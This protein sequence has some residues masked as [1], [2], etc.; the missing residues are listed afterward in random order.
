MAE[1]ELCLPYRVLIGND[2]VAPFE[3]R[4]W[5]LPNIDQ[6]LMYSFIVRPRGQKYPGAFR[7]YS[8][9]ILSVTERQ[10]LPPSGS[11]M[12]SE[13]LFRVVV[14]NTGWNPLQYALWAIVFVPHFRLP[15]NFQFQHA[16][17]GRRKIP[18]FFEPFTF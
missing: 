3:T 18:G 7:T 16:T 15:Y 12:P 9:Q 14:Q 8:M 10:H 5:T 2:N 4:V 1:G 13:R 11:D 6:R 17:D